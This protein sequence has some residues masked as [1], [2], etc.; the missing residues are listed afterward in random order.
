VRKA[1]WR[2]RTSLFLG[3]RLPRAATGLE[4][5]AALH[6][7]L[8]F[9][10]M[11]QQRARTPALTLFLGRRGGSLAL[12]LPDVSRS[13]AVRPARVEPTRAS[14]VRT[15]AGASRDYLQQL[16]DDKERRERPLS[17]RSRRS[18]SVRVPTSEPRA[19]ASSSES[20]FM[21]EA[22]PRRREQRGARLERKRRGMSLRRARPALGPLARRWRQSRLP[23][24][25]PP[26][27]TAIS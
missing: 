22:H 15:P 19:L 18:T 11:Q 16:G 20:F 12:P 6:D 23:R 7:S 1:A 26:R 27:S 4:L 21:T 10:L 17:L 5:L 3:S 25:S 8:C 9:A 13:S 14:H 2:A 24:C